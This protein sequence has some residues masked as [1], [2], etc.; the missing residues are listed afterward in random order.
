MILELLSAAASAAPNPLGIWDA[1]VH[2]FSN[3]TEPAAFAAFL[4]V[5]MIDIV[6]AATT[7]SSSARSPRACRRISARRSSSSA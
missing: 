4:Q 1:I 5:L 3:I 6:L 2:D 7:R